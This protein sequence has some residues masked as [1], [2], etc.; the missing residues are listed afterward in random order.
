MAASPGLI[1]L[2]DSFW[3][4]RGA[5]DRWPEFVGP[6]GGDSFSERLL[7]LAGGERERRRWCERSRDLERSLY[8]LSLL[9]SYFR[10]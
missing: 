1:P 2:K 6:D 7:R 4:G 8:F 3:D 5:R 9:S 10:S